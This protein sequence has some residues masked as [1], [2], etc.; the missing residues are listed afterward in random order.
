MK[1]WAMLRLRNKFARHTSHIAYTVHTLSSLY[2][3]G[4]WNTLCIVLSKQYTTLSLCTVNCTVQCTEY[5]KQ[6]SVQY[7]LYTTARTGGRNTPP[8]LM[9]RLKTGQVSHSYTGLCS[10]VQCT[11]QISE[12]NCV[13]CI[14]LHVTAVAYSTVQPSTEKCTDVQCNEV[15]VV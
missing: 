12:V 2:W 15:S 6:C 13:Q 7:L 1:L 8:G 14:G 5:T 3:Q 11:A 10:E 4:T 9:T